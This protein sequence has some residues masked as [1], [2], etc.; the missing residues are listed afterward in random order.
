[1]KNEGEN[2]CY[3]SEMSII[4]INEMRRRNS[5]KASRKSKKIR[6]NIVRR[7]A[8][9]ALAKRKSKK[10]ANDNENI[11]QWRLKMKISVNQPSS[12][13]KYRKQSIS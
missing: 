9:M 8:K 7:L 13:E 5:V 11:I 10:T 12:N 6:R 1:M 4:A 2:Q 3:R